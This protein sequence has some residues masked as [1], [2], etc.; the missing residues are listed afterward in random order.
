MPSFLIGSCTTISDILH[1]SR[2][3]LYL[4]SHE[5]WTKNNSKVFCIP[6]IPL[7]MEDHFEKYT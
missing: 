3:S 7:S 6:E 2:Q 5:G 1:H 4:S